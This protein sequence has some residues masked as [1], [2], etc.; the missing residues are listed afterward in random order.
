MTLHAE[1]VRL[2]RERN[3]FLGLYSPTPATGPNWTL[4]LLI[5]IQYVHVSDAASFGTSNTRY[6]KINQGT[7]ELTHKVL[8]SHSLRD[9]KAPNL[10]DPSDPLPPQAQG[11]FRAC[12]SALDSTCGYRSHAL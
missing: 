5:L 6:H 12:G 2:E 11:I 7:G 9:K 8:K 10:K 3:C 1:P 4:A